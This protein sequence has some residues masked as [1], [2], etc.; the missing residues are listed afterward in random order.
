M[1]IKKA[2]VKVFSAN[3]LQLISSLIVGFIVPIILSI[4]EYANLKTYALYVS[5][6]GFF[7]LGFVD[8]L[9]IKYGGKNL[10][11]IDKGVLKGEHTFLI[12]IELIL[13]FILF[14][15]SLILKNPI[16]LLFSISVLP[17]VLNSFYK[18][19]YQAT[20]KF[21]KYSRIVYIYTI[22][23]T[24]LNVLLVFVFRSK[25]FIYYCLTTFMANLLALLVFEIQFIK[26]FHKEKAVITKDVW[27]NIKVGF[28]ILLGNLAVI[29]LFEI[30]KWFVKWFLSTED[31]AYYAFAV[32]MLNII[33]VLVSAISITFY[34][35]LFTSNQPETIHQLKKH[36][37]SLGAFSSLGFFALKWIVNHFIAKY[38]PSLD[39]IAITFA[40]FP[41][42]ILINGLY[43]NLYKVNKNEKKYFRV[44]VSVLIVSIL[45]NIAAILIFRNTLA[46]AVATILTL[47]T[48]VTYSGIDLKSVYNDFKTFAY[49]M[50]S[51]VSFFLTSHLLGWLVGAV[52]YLMVIIIL[53][54]WYN[55]EIY[56]EILK[57]IEKLFS[58]AISHK[59]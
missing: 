39:I 24:I 8:G 2:I 15:V 58:K 28:F 33:N 56:R 1:N 37:L 19:L 27:K 55:R 35:Y 21:D 49:I 36:L 12:M 54:Y 10:D 40:A 25:N 13:S 23:Y 22:T 43:V 46:I 11:S 51:A 42:M 31:F 52:V 41:S 20:G 7:H 29:G 44:V 32:S 53:T 50:L 38:I 59:Q 17:I 57:T 5:Y 34:N 45:Y 26:D 16:V 3:F 6:V 48:W 4:G 14:I 47:F 18:N 9:Y 30:D